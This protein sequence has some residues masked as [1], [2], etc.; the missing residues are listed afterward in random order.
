MV[1]DKIL[2]VVFVWLLVVSMFVGVVPVAAATTW[3]VDDSGGADFTKIQDAVNAA[4]A[5]DTIIVY[6]GTYYENVIV[7][8]QL[9]LRGVDTGSGM[10]E[11][12][13]GRVPD[14][15]FNLLVN[16]PSGDGSFL[17]IGRVWI[18]KDVQG[19]PYGPLLLFDVEYHGSGDYRWL[20]I[21]M[22]TDNNPTTGYPIHGIGADYRVC[23]VGHLI[24]QPNVERWVSN[25]GTWNYWNIWSR[26]GFLDC[27]D[28][29]EGADKRYKI[30]FLDYETGF[31]LTD[32]STIRLVFESL[33]G[34]ASP[35]TVDD[36]APNAGSV[37]VDVQNWKTDYRDPFIALNVTADS[38]IIDG[39]KLTA[40]DKALEV[41]SVDSQISN[42]TVSSNFIGIVLDSSNN[43]A[44][45]DNTIES[46]EDE[47][48]LVKTSENGIIKNNYVS[49]NQCGIWLYSSSNNQ[50]YNNYLNNTF[51]AYDGENNIWN[52]AKTLGT[53]IIGGPYLGGNYWSD[54][55]GV[56][57]DGDGLGDTLLPYNSSGYIQNGGDFLPLVYG[58]SPTK[59]VHNI[60]T[61]EDFTTIQEAIDDSDTLDGHTITIDPGTYN[62]NV[63]VTKSLTIRSTS[64]NPEDTIVQAA[65]PDDHVFNVTADYVNISG[66]TVK[67]TG[68]QGAG[69]YLYDVDNCR[70]KDNNITGNYGY[71]IFLNSSNSNNITDNSVNYSYDYGIFLIE[72]KDNTIVNNNVMFTYIYSI[73]LDN[74]DNNG[75]MNNTVIGGHNGIWLWH[76]NGSILLNNVVSY[77][78]YCLPL[79]GSSHNKLINNTASYG[80]YGISLSSSS[81]NI[82]TNNT[83]SDNWYGALLGETDNNELTNN[84]ISNNSGYGIYLEEDSS[85]NTIYNNYFNNTNNSY[86]DGN[87]T[88]NIAKTAG[89]NIIGGPYLGGNYW[90]DYTGADTDG[91]GLGDTLLPYNSGGNITKGGDF[92]PL[93]QVG[94]VSP[95][96][97]SFAPPSPVSDS[98]GSTR[99]FNVT[100][101]QV[102]NVS[103]QINGTEVQT[104]T[105]V[106][107]ASYTN[108]S[109]AVGTWNVS[110]I[111]RNENGTDLQTWIWVVS[112][113]GLPVHNIDT[114]EDFATIQG[115]IDDPNTLNGHTITVDSGTYYENVDVTKSLTIRSTSG[116][117]E[118][119]IV[120]ASNPDD[121]VFNVTADYVNI[122]GFTVEG[123][124]D[125][126]KAGIYLN[127]V[128]CCEIFNVSTSNNY[129]IRLDNSIN[130][131]IIDNYA[132]D[133]S[134]GI[135][136]RNSINNTI[137]DNYAYDNT[138][139]GIHLWSS[140]N[141][142]I[143]GNYAYNNMHGI[144]IEFSSNTINSN[145]AYNNNFDGICIYQSSNNTITDN[146]IYNN[147]RCGIFINYLGYNLIYNNYFSNANNALDL[148]GNNTW[149]ITKTLGTNIMGS[150]YL[151]GNC[152]SDYIGADTDSD[153][154]GDTLLPYNSSGNITNGGDWLPLVPVGV[155]PPNIISFAPPSPV[156][157]SEGATRTFNITI[158][159]VVNV[160]WLINGTEVQINETVTEAFYTNLS[161][162]IGTWNV[163]AI[164][165][166]END[167]DMQTW[168]WD[169]T[170]VGPL[171]VHNLGTGE[172]F[173]TIQ[174]AIDDSDTL[175]GHT[176]IVDPGTYNENV[177]V[178]KSLTI[179]STSGDPED[180]IVQAA[181]SDDHVF[182]VTADYVNIS[183]FT[184]TGAMGSEE[185]GIYLNEV[186]NCN[187]SDNNASYNH[188]GIHL[189]NSSNNS[190]TNNIAHGFEEIR[191]HL[192]TG[193]WLIESSNNIITDNIFKKCGICVQGSELSHFNTHIIE[194]NTANGK[195]IYY[196][197]D[198]QDIKV[199][200]DAGEV[201]LSNCS[202]MTIENI[203]ASYSGVGIEL[204]YTENSVITGSVT[205]SNMI[206]I[207]LYES[208]D[209]SINNNVVNS[210][211]EV[212][213]WLS[214]TSNN[215]IYLNNFVNNDYN[216]R[217]SDST[218]LWNS[219]EPITYK[220][221]ESTFTNYIGNY[222]DD[223][224]GSDTDGDGIGDNP[225]S[226]DTDVDNYPLTGGF[227]N[228][229]TPTELP[230]LT[231]SANNISFS[232]PFPVI[233]ETVT[234]NATI[235]NVG[236][237]DASN[238]VMQFFDG[239]PI[240]GTQI[241]VDQ[242]IPLIT[243]GGN[244]TVN[245][246]WIAEAGVHE[247]YVKIDPD[248][249]IVEVNEG[250]NV[251][252]KL[253]IIEDITYEGILNVRIV[254]PLN[255]SFYS[256]GDLLRFNTTISDLNGDYL[257]SNVTAYATLSGPENESKIIPLSSDSNFFV[258]EYYVTQDDP[259]G[260]WIANVTAH[261]STHIGYNSSLLFFTGPYS[262]SARS[263]KETYVLNEVAKFEAEAYKLG[264]SSRVL[265]DENVS[266]NLSIYNSESTLVFG[267][268]AMSY[269]SISDL[270]VLEVDVNLLG[271]GRFNVSVVGED[272]SGNIENTTLD[273]F[274]TEDFEVNIN[275]DKI[276]YDRGEPIN[277]TGSAFF[278]NGSAVSNATVTLEI[279]VE[280]FIRTFITN[281]RENGDFNFT[282]YP[283]DYEAGNY[284]L[285]AIVD[286]HSLER[287]AKEVF[288]I[289]GLY[290]RPES[291]T[292]DMTE[293]YEYKLNLTLFNLGEN[294]LTGVNA[295][296]IDKNTSDN[297]FG[298]LNTSNLPNTLL[299]GENKTFT[300]IVQASEGELGETE[301]SVVVSTVQTSEEIS[302]I[303][304]RVHADNP[305]LEV[306]SMKIEAGLNL[307]KSIIKSFT[308]SNRGYGTLKNVTLNQSVNSWMQ[309]ISNKSLED[310]PP[311]ENA[312]IYFVI[313][314]FQIDVGNYSGFINISSTN[315]EPASVEV[316]AH[317]SNS[318]TGSLRFYVTDPF[319][320]NISGANIS[321]VDETNF[322]TY[323]LTTDERGYALI[324][325]LP[326]GRYIYDVFSGNNSMFPQM[327]SVEVD[328]LPSPKTV[329][330][331]LGM[332]LIDFTWDLE[333]TEITDIYNIILKMKFET[334]VPVPVLVAHPSFL[335]Y[336]FEP[337]GI[338]N[339]NLHLINFGLVSIK[340][341][342]LKDVGLGHYADMEFRVND[343]P[344][345]KAKSSV[346][347]PFTISFS[348]TPP[349]NSIGL[350]GFVNIRGSYLH[351]V[352]GNNVRAITGTNVPVTINTVNISF[353]PHYCVMCGGEYITSGIE[354]ENLKL[355][356]YAIAVLTVLNHDLGPLR[357]VTNTFYINAT[358][359]N[360]ENG[361]KISFTP[362][363]GL[364]LKKDIINPLEL[365]PDEIVGVF[366]IVHEKFSDS[367]RYIITENLL[368]YSRSTSYSYS[369][370]SLFFQIPL[371][372]VKN[373]KLS[374][375][376]P[377]LD[378][379]LIG[380]FNPTSIDPGNSSIL[381]LNRKPLSA[382]LVLPRFI[383]GAA[384][385]LFGPPGDPNCLAV[386][387]IGGVEVNFGVKI[388]NVP[389]LPK[390]ITWYWPHSVSLNGT[391]L[392]PFVCHAGG[393]FMWPHW[394]DIPSNGFSNYSWNGSRI[395]PTVISRT[396]HEVVRLS[397]SQNA[398]MERDA[399]WAGLGIYNR[400]SDKSVD[401]IDVD[402]IIRD[403]DGYAND[404]FFIQSPRL[405][406]IS[407]IN[408]GGS[409]P[410][411]G[412][413]KAQWLIIPKPGAGGTGAEGKV[414][415][416]SANISYYVDGVYYEFSTLDVQ[417]LVK[418][419][420]QIVLDYYIPSDV[421]ANK[422][423]KL[424]VKATNDGHGTARE[425][426][427]KS[428]QPVIYDNAA[429]L[430][431]DFKILGGSESDLVDVDFGDIDPG[432]SDFKWWEM[433]TTLDGSFTEFTG[434]YTH[435]SE[436][437]GMETSLIKELNTHIILRDIDTGD[438]VYDM[439]VDSDQDK[440][441]DYVIDALYGTSTEVLLMDYTVI[442]GPTQ[443]NPILSISTKKVDGKWICI[444]IED[445]YEN[446]VPILLVASSDGRIISPH[447]YWMRDGRILIVDD[448]VTEYNITFGTSG[449]M[450]TKIIS[451]APESPVSDVEVAT[452]TFNISINQTVDVSWL[453][454]GTEVQTNT[455]LTESTYTNTSAA[456]GT[457]N[458]S[459]IA[460]NE[461]G[462]DM[463]TWIWN[464]TSEPDITPPASI[465]NL[466]NTTYEQTYIN[467]AWIN[468]TDP[469]FSHVMIYLDG[470]WQE[471]TSEQ[472][473]NA[474]G[475][476]ADTEYEIGTRTVDSSGN[477]NKSWVNQTAKTSA[478][479]DTTPPIITN[480]T[481]TDITS[482][483]AIITWDTDE[484]SDS[485]VKYGTK[486]G[487]YTLQKHDTENVTSHSVDL[488]G[489]LPNTKY[490]FV[491]NSTDLSENS[492]ESEEYNFTT[493]QTIQPYKISL[494][495]GQ[496]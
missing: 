80:G 488:S 176:I 486:L 327:G 19:S 131:T 161:A 206:G 143:I 392:P 398:T 102:V 192:E 30:N 312:S 419:Q 37:A 207:Y 378:S 90:S 92:L 128:E 489:L 300:L 47:G 404:R 263:D 326:V 270:F 210:N 423:F 146:Y 356:K 459:A 302:E 49:E 316:A 140:S 39:F 61:G 182:E 86:D 2:A 24:E 462:T 221:N 180:T 96:I 133:N 298:I 345:I 150:S 296:L 410:A 273:F 354:P 118:D 31:Q 395:R 227:E 26:S 194:S 478:I 165:T 8:K 321:L 386:L 379:I 481:A 215:N 449:L 169:V 78:K 357:E 285:K 72:S 269:D 467:W 444:S 130:N 238:V 51:N 25:S 428:A 256:S 69:M 21:Y 299:P 282:F 64:G 314:S 190:I 202:G 11:I 70:I 407:D 250:N 10:P 108:L 83:A 109:A 438:V 159:Q 367:Q 333:P 358:N 468:P 71:G 20:R 189:V 247:I 442:M 337:G 99:T 179:R 177:D 29:P 445:P 271:V 141:N 121:H 125:S 211:V 264:I 401:N 425:F 237:V 424:A 323:N 188:D 479:P 173:A 137:T 66:F 490:Y 475:L 409:I 204:A 305:I 315:H 60:N 344:E 255:Y 187:I 5:G 391:Q 311:G 178:T 145:Y 472:S 35:I 40:S 359:G 219:T 67:G 494:S 105:S 216:V 439:L 371:E 347:V 89:I 9:T 241:D 15:Q 374:I 164:A 113:I 435:S 477:I 74:S 390:N 122:S 365:V 393:D 16:D 53:N 440:I 232:N 13:G 304:V 446:K 55:T 456:I 152:W 260:V 45:T 493:E 324:D 280:S 112:G 458:V 248:D 120:N 59:P 203:N 56:D 191:I 91:D 328:P 334:D 339:G 470:V 54:Y 350:T 100:I 329:N 148:V 50:I 214:Y 254:E 290:L 346:Q 154:L 286:C 42:N 76:S 117:P 57:T 476:S 405:T 432:E 1:S 155:A 174:G 288:S 52:I 200:E 465:T 376:L 231:L 185:A 313:S 17:D 276:V 375:G 94:L 283:F 79:S 306:S 463:Q 431:I 119:T 355:D 245:V 429:G 343:I 361:S 138:M 167:T 400:M 495:V 242:T 443:E 58:A 433:V 325:D 33:N 183:G 48:I 257:S 259:K 303:I 399:F 421:L 279:N 3:T 107:W 244:E 6:S 340:D 487:N 381:T 317:V 366:E 4:S 384:V 284:K 97:I 406:G 412:I 275:T 297:V 123:A 452:R 362:A 408:G 129:G 389:P 225:Y 416:I 229:F 162:A 104:N 301:F 430:M 115:A 62:E 209:N 7:D 338:V 218:N 212:G 126:Y 292:I 335:A 149:N 93:T 491:V 420:P 82:L 160:T 134:Y 320:G 23:P 163:S 453:I 186:D 396:I 116:N 22:D 261:N 307:N 377:Y 258:G 139:G 172:D 195:P 44:I 151:G 147:N 135:F 455:N 349:P 295:N 484:P 308:L 65:N 14:H 448:P 27:T 46:N 208:F 201:I 341:V 278:F 103:W 223:Y 77:S 243:A 68:F 437:G 394:I 63:D 373:S 413:A 114:G 233:G 136:L 310:L 415:N 157:D 253:I 28:G 85:N 266:L 388:P 168:V 287:G 197:K 193:V 309:L 236:D 411:L 289:N 369:K 170:P 239:D 351:S 262:I 156:S 447:N 181:N 75:L 158:D 485:L 319:G 380:D 32:A 352:G 460:T 473:Y 281:S 110:A 450:P 496:R 175:N 199:P 267:P 426:N 331:S 370:F 73:V 372:A 461:N 418:P 482:N 217:S 360:P 272:S 127:S 318:S 34:D 364:L 226:I 246:T 332:S 451:Y 12:N 277:I 252:Y 434:S 224:T 18:D 144:R 196:Y 336:N 414:Y 464:V 436:L 220:Y 492:N 38:C 294:I 106:T 417:I 342:K 171:S 469:D 474:T 422:P 153:G 84:T 184:V 132:Y 251:A 87:N 222:W 403:S 397:I 98:E 441:P 205:S 291:D 368:Y 43:V 330:I 95:N 402:I 457:W 198:T 363:V 249:D 480:V 483:S 382:G 466:I 265:S 234:I 274:V 124:T 471:N 348:E 427:I 385:F 41:S 166:N 454:N 353:D 293:G 142:T 383:G 88:W 235:H 111:A 101:D 81:N 268:N 240:N 387:P 228:Y 230:D 36:T 213:I 322:S